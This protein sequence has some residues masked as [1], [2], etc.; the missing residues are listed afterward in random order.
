VYHIIIVFQQRLA[1]IFSFTTVYAVKQFDSF[2]TVIN[3]AVDWATVLFASHLIH[4]LY[5]MF[6]MSQAC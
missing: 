4:S 1:A 3:S 2:T 6:L 5:L